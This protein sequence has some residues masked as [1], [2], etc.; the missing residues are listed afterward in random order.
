M[1]EHFIGQYVDTQRLKTVREVEEE[2][3]REMHSLCRSLTLTGTD[4]FHGKRSLLGFVGFAYFFK[5]QT[6]VKMVPPSIQTN[7]FNAPTQSTS[8]PRRKWS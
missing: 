3:T 5:S 2:T 1:A 7:S 6:N 8:Q 4:D